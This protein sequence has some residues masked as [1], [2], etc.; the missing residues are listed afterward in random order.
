MNRR[1]GLTIRAARHAHLT[2]ASATAVI[3]AAAADST[4]AERSLVGLALPY[5]APG[6]TNVGQ[7]TASAGV[8]RWPADLRRIRVFA[9]HDRNRPVGYV[10]AIEDTP[11]GLRARMHIA[12]TPDGDTVLAEAHEG[13][14]DAISVELDDV[15]VDGQ[16]RITSAELT[17]LALVPVPAFEDARLAAS[18]GAGADPAGGADAVPS[19]P[20]VAAAL[21]PGAVAAAARGALAAAR[22]PAGLYATRGAGRHARL[23]LAGMAQLVAARFRNSDRSAAALN[24]ALADVTPPSVNWA[25]VQPYQWLGE[26]WTPEY[27][28]LDWANSVTS[29]ALTSMKVVGWKRDTSQNPRIRPYAG[30]KADIPTDN[31]LSFVPIEQTAVRHAVG[32]DFD[33]IFLDFGNE[34]VI[35]TWLRL[36]S[37]S[38][39]Q[40]LDTAIG[41]AVLGEATDGGTAAGMVPAMTLAARLLKRVGARVSWVAVSSDLF[42]DFLD[43]PAAEA[44][45]WLAGSSSVD[46]AGGL[47]ANGN[48]SVNTLPR[49]FESPALD[50]GTVV[51][52]DRRAVTQYTPRGNPFQVRA[53]DLPRGGLDVAVFGYSAELVNDPLGIVKVTVD[54][55]A[56]AP[57]KTTA[58][59]AK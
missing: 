23:S 45:W 38:Y 5:G 57:A 33:R 9:G 51:A 2:L 3:E 30:N 28:A 12:A 46:I 16:G 27:L 42:G 15:D 8:V 50:D 43:I 47:D 48:A 24:A 6:R 55:A 20:A 21:D 54:G 49:V 7:V 31:T 44:P 59:A 11:A 25:A 13:I 14:R 1:T 26:V 41:A 17:G 4:D 53:V 19:A 10:T 18:P 58:K 34:T 29:D 22:G 37:Q 52:G 40:V 39:A 36:V 56:A 32:A 35:Q